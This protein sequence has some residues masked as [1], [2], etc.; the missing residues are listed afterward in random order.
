L[1]EVPV[2]HS[3]P[4]TISPTS[5]FALNL[6]LLFDTV[7][8]KRIIET[9]TYTGVGT[10]AIIASAIED[11]LEQ[12][13]LR[14]DE[15]RFFSIELNR[16]LVQRAEA[17]LRDSKLDRYVT[18]L[19]GLSVPRALLPTPSEIK[20]RCVD[21]IAD[22]PIVADHHESDRVYRYY[23]ET[24]GHEGAEDDLL[25]RCLEE[26]DGRPDF[27]LL[28]SGGHMGYVEFEYLIERLKGP[29]YIMLDDVFHVKHHLSFARMVHDR[30]FDVRCVNREKYGFAIARFEPG[31]DGKGK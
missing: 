5:D 3:D 12:G 19:Q 20:A 18:L 4:S 31:K 13:G 24:A 21:G 8:P 9:G 22:L 23:S 27:V 30:R 16:T 25:G 17:N 10:T 11:V 2:A 7:R 15:V 29:C 14:A 28:D 1:V 26:F 6:W